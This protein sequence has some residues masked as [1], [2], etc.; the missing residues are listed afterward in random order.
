MN[1][2]SES[3]DIIKN[4]AS[5]MPH[6]PGIYKMVS[7]SG[8][9]LYVGKAKN[10]PK[11]VLS[12]CNFSSLSNRIKMMVSQI[13]NIE[14][15]VTNSESEALLLESDLI[16]TL[17]PPYNISLKDGKTYPYIVLDLKHEYPAIFKYR[18][19]L[20]KNIKGYGPFSSAKQV[21]IAINELQKIFLIRNC[22]DTYFQNRSRPCL[23]YE[24]KKCSAPC[25]KKISHQEY[26]QN[27]KQAQSFLNGKSHKVHQ[28]MVDE[29]QKYSNNMQ[30]ETAAAIRD[31]IK[32]LTAT[33][34]SNVFS[35]MVISGDLDII[36]IKKQ[37][38]I[39][40]V[41][42]F[43][44]R[45]GKN[46][47]DITN[48][49]DDYYIDNEFVEQFICQ[50][51]KNKMPANTILIN[52]ENLDSTVIGD[53]LHIMH[54]IKVKFLDFTKINEN[55]A[56][57]IE[58][59]LSEALSVKLK[60]K[61]QISQNLEEISKIFA[62]NREVQ[63]IEVYDNSHTSGACAVGCMI[64]YD[65]IG[66]NKGQYRVFN[67]Q[68]STD[69][70]DYKMLSEV[71]RRRL[72]S[73]KTPYPDMMLID[74]G[75]AH[76]SIAHGVLL[77]LGR[78]DIKLVA[79]SKGVDRNSGREF[80]HQIDQDPFQLPPDD[81][82]LNFLQILRDEAHKH[83]IQSHRRRMIKSL[84]RSKLD[85]IPDIG[86][87]R[88]AML[89]QHFGSVEALMEANVNDITMVKGISDSIAEKIF[90]HIHQ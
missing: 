65:T 40:C 75:A 52:A 29:M 19:K 20:E 22:S 17:N 67:I 31:R 58:M 15:L 51:Y 62:I 21:N 42:V 60:D 25:V 8:D 55:L 84:R 69:G 2:I 23:Q 90:N 79:I 39:V 70:D 3:I 53:A 57:F 47:G 63:R 13:K 44:I 28:W 82:R 14:Y 80:F 46:Y 85:S 10:L 24:I 12:Y 72:S 6:L 9:V 89:L 45:G 77:E 43:V 7:S 59:N 36:G 83:A 27:I 1:F 81:K 37:G 35:S 34:A 86:P 30:Y 33:Q 61:M 54:Q 74:G 88:K 26:H 66:F 16:K 11:R 18:G 71:L 49:Y 73:N 48:F 56:N 38:G 78:L 87:K 5:N 50:F 4:I 68:S 32:F 76:L 41:K 64:V